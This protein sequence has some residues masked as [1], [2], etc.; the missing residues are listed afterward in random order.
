VEEVCKR[1]KSRLPTSHRWRRECGEA[2]EKL[3]KRLHPLEKEA[4]SSRY[5]WPTCLWTRRCSR[6]WWREP[7]GAPAAGTPEGSAGGRWRRGNPARK[8]RAVASLEGVFEV[9]QRRACEVFVQQRSRGRQRR[10]DAAMHRISAE[11][12]RVG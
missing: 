4:G 8:C 5:R 7:G 2:K 1:L 10:K 12:P 3:V 9:S 11:N 6:N